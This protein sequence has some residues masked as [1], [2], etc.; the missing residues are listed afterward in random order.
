[1]YL[2]VGLGNP[3][4]KYA[5]HRHN[6]GFMIVDALSKEEGGKF[7]QEKE[8]LLSKIRIKEKTIL[9]SKPQT[10]MNLSGK[11]VESLKNFYKI[12]LQNILVIHDDIDLPL[13]QIKFQKKRGSGGHNG[14]KSIHECLKSDDYCRLKV[15]VGK[16][17]NTHKHVLSDFT[18]EETAIL[19]PTIKRCLDGISIFVNEGVEKA[20][21]TSNFN[22]EDKK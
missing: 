5:F 4:T 9:L 17:E 2:I 12:E 19:I 18:E 16:K 15:G 7:N 21:N 1:M 20:A 14:I 22:P 6:V 8:S 11:S 10:F 3:G 13:G